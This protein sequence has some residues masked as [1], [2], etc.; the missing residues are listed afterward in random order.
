[1]PGL[2]YTIN[3]KDS[4]RLPMALNPSRHSTLAAT[5]LGTTVA[6]NTPGA[7]ALKTALDALFNHP[8]TA[9]FFCKQLIQRL[10]TSNPSPAYVA[11]VAGVFVNNGAGVRGDIPSVLAALLL[12]DEARS[13]VGLNSVSF[14][15]LREPMVRLVQWGRSFGIASA[16]GTW[17]L[18]DTTRS[19]TQL[20][21]SPLRSPSVFNFFRPGYVPPGTALA[22]SQTPAPEFQ[23]VNETTVGGYLN[24]MQDVIRNGFN[25]GTPAVPEPSYTAYV[26][27]V[28]CSYT[29]ELALVLDPVALV[30]RLSLRLCADQ[31]SAANQN[32]IASALASPALSPT[33]TAAQKLDRVAAAVLLVMASA[34]YLV[35]K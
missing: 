25:I 11:R 13:P 31:L 30:K 33:S 12:D 24:F 34:D 1:V 29:A 9:P 20:G 8:N 2:T 15:K 3:P 27:D 14:G 21:Q 10:V 23:L 5:F 32:L 22:T 16:A 26:R 18:F 17:K 35:Q 28:T 4:V 7:T 6:A 19:D